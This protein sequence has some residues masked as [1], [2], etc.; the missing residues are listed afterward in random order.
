MQ[1]TPDD[2]KG[3]GQYLVNERSRIG[4]EQFDNGYLSTVMYKVGYHMGMGLSSVPNKGHVACLVS[5][6]DGWVKIG[7][8]IDKNFVQ[9]NSKQDL[10]D[11]LNK[12]G[13]FR[14][15][16]MEELVRIIMHQKSRMNTLDDSFMKW[17][18]VS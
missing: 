15:A 12:I 6:S 4:K 2:I 1:F 16:T 13:T 18:T 7:E 5:M 11:Y 8:I 9:W 14:L 3:S 17:N 10:C